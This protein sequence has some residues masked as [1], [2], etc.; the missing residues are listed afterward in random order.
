MEKNYECK[1]K[2]EHFQFECY[3][4]CPIKRA[5]NIVVMC[6]VRNN[7]SNVEWSPVFNF[8]Y[9]YSVVG[10]GSKFETLESAIVAAKIAGER[11]GLPVC[12]SMKYANRY[13]SLKHGLNPLWK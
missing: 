6:G 9:S 7:D 13:E 4:G 1:N 3:T 11:Y 12:V 8:R 2:C 10:Y 5:N